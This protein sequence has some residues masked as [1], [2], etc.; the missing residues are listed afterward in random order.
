MCWFADFDGYDRKAVAHT[1]NLEIGVRKV[2]DITLHKHQSTKED[3]GST[4]K[5][6]LGSARDDLQVA[7]S[8]LW[9]LAVNSSLFTPDLK[10][11]TRCPEA[12]G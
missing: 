8:S 11:A 6:V 12:Q 3:T 4:D 7:L 10:R 5:A 1:Y 9:A 2:H